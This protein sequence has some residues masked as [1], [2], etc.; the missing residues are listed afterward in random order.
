MLEIKDDIIV[1]IITNLIKYVLASLK[2]DKYVRV[3][4]VR[5]FIPLSFH[6]SKTK[7]RWALVKTDQKTLVI[8][9]IE[10]NGIIND[11]I[12]YGL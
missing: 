9:I 5:T 1:I 6:S 11:V 4:C 12:N 2:N 10:S 8:V 3:T 7:Q